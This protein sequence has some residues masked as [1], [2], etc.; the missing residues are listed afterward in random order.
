[1]VLR[2][3]PVKFFDLS[4]KVQRP[5]D[6]DDVLRRCKDLG[7]GDGLGRVGDDVDLLDERERKSA[8]FAGMGSSLRKMPR[9]SLSAIIPMTK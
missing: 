9:M 6:T 4:S 7:L 8:Q 2:R 3:F 1:M 5:C